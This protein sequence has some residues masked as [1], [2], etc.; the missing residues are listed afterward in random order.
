M[1]SALAHIARL[2]RKLRRLVVLGWVSRA[3]EVN[4]LLD[5]RLRWMAHRDVGFLVNDRRRVRR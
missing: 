5:E 3:P 2:D 1:D 4:R